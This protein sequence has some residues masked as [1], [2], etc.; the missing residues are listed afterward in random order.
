V[1]Y[2][3]GSAHY[4]ITNYAPNTSVAVRNDKTG[5]TA[6]IRTDHRGTGCDDVDVEVDCGHLVAQPIVATGVAADGNPGTSSARAMVP[7][8]VAPCS[9]SDG[10]KAVSER[11][12]SLSGTAVALI[13]AG[14]AGGLL[15]AGAI[16]VVV[17]RRRRSAP[18]E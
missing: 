11:G 2:D 5:D 18:S 4:C 6:E 1:T 16:T 13:V 3:A 7:G 17:V 8:N 10:S 9:P 14:G 12:D 15:A